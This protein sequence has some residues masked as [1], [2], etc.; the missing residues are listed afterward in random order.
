M[1]MK[2]IEP[3]LIPKHSFPIC[4]IC[5]KISYVHEISKYQNINYYSN[6]FNR[7]FFLAKSY[8]HRNTVIRLNSLIQASTMKMVESSTY[9]FCVLKLQLQQ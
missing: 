1:H 9:D 8:N 2:S 7:Y 5:F 6:S 4:I 3:A